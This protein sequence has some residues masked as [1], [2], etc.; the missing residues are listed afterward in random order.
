MAEWYLV[1]FAIKPGFLVILSILAIT[2]LGIVLPL[3][4]SLN[5]DYSLAYDADRAST[6]FTGII[7]L[8]IIVATGSLGSY[9]IQM[10]LRQGL[11]FDISLNAFFAFTLLVTSVLWFLSVKATSGYKLDS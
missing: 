4:G 2:F 10:S 1:P 9:F 8:I 11:R 5:P 7:S 6:S 3:F